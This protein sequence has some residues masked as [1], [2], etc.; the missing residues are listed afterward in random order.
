MTYPADWYQWLR[1][2]GLDSPLELRPILGGR[3]NRGFEVKAGDSRFFLKEYR[4]QARLNTEFDFLLNLDG[5]WTAKPLARRDSLR[6][7]LYEFVEGRRPEAPIGLS[8][9]EQARQFLQ[10]LQSVDRRRLGMASDAC[11]SLEAHWQA[12]KGRVDGVKRTLLEPYLSEWK[13]NWEPRLE[14]LAGLPRPPE[15]D[16]QEL[17]VSPS[18]FGFHNALQG[19]DRR[20]TFI[21]LEYAGLDEPSKIVCDFFAQPSVPAPIAGL[22]LFLDLLNPQAASRLEW[23]WRVTG[24]KWA[25]IVLKQVLHKDNF[26]GYELDTEEQLKKLRYL[27]R[28]QTE[29]GMFLERLE[30][31]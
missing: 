19:K 26:S 29:V 31:H 2:V 3:N 20:L 15:V 1:E 10:S 23:M 9:V 4:D 24:I 8:E 6:L 30:P 21:D 14:L 16:T 13:T 12:V 11:G 18:D 17:M 28:R 22:P 27:D 7:A 25:C 5:Q